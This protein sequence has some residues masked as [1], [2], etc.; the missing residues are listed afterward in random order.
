MVLMS[1]REQI[2]TEERAEG[3][4][5]LSWMALDFCLMRKKCS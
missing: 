2:K 3:E 1:T 4:E 5:K